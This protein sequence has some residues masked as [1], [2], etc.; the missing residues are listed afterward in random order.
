MEDLEEKL[1]REYKLIAFDLDGTLLDNSKKIPDVVKDSIMEAY[2]AGK[3][4]VFSTGRNI[5]ELT[6]FRKVE[7][8][9]YAIAINGSY[10]YDLQEDKAM[11]TNPIPKE[12]VEKLFEFL[13]TKEIHL[14]VHSD[15]Y[16]LDKEILDNPERHH[17]ELLVKTLSTHGIQIPSVYDLYYSKNMDIYKVNIYLNS[18]EERDEIRKELSQFDDDFEMVYSEGYSL[19]L[20]KK[21]VSKGKGL[22]YLCDYLNIDI[23]ETIA[24]GDNEND[25]EAIK[26]A[27]LGIA[28]ENGAEKVKE[29]A[30]VI[31][32]TNEEFGCKTAIE[33]YLLK[34]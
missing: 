7:A 32:P 1:K 21:G 24:V 6:D 31:V 19:E 8:F 33:K 11:V 16:Y 27:G 12:N 14:G 22:E 30:D 23:K 34:K 26:A 9:R 2:N 4:L 20:S 28:M 25:L 13:K 10:I 15:D 5:A 29:V 17:I 18:N 3:I